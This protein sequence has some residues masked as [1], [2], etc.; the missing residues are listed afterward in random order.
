MLAFRNWVC[1]LNNGLIVYGKCAESADNNGSIADEEVQWIIA[2]WYN[3][4]N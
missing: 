3:A 2:S 1:V 4:I